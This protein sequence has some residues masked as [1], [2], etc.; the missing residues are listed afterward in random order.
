MGTYTD[1]DLVI[2]PPPRIKEDNGEI[3]ADRITPS[4]SGGGYT[5]GQLNPTPTLTAGQEVL[6]IVTGPNGAKEY[7]IVEVNLRK[8]FGY[9]LRLVS[10]DR[11]VPD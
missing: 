6:Y 10:L 8:N 9:E 4:H 11:V 3:T 2:T 7:A 1:S 5:V